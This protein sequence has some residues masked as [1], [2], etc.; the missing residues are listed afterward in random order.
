MEWSALLL[1]SVAILLGFIAPLLLVV[2]E[3]TG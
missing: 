2:F 3:V 1:A